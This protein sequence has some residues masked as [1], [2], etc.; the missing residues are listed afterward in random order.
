MYM[1]LSYNKNYKKQEIFITGLH[2]LFLRLSYT[3][4]AAN[5][6]ILSHYLN[7]YQEIKENS[8]TKNNV[9]FLHLLI[10]QR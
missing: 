7:Y 1:A 10:F 2:I 8:I 5:K 9:K 6:E 4:T 3:T